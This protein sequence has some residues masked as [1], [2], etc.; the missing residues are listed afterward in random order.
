MSEFL[1]NYEDWLASRSR[2]LSCRF[3]LPAC[4]CRTLLERFLLQYESQKTAW[5]AAKRVLI[6]QKPKPGLTPSETELITQPDP[7]LLEDVDFLD[8]IEVRLNDRE[9]RAVILFLQGYT[10]SE[11]ADS[12][13]I[14]YLNAWRA[15]ESAVE[16]LREEYFEC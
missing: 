6:Q 10:R 16:K 15:V 1:E 14:S 13:G 8:F 5:L 11:I 7:A 4:D 2:Y 3:G 12:L 9:R